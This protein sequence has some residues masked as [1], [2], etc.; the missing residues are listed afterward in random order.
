MRRHFLFS[1]LLVLMM[2]SC[3]S[4]T[5]GLSQ[6]D[7]AAIDEL[8][9]GLINAII[10]ADAT[11]YAEL[12]SED[13][14]L[15]HEGS[16]IITGKSELTAHNIAIFESISVTSLSLTPIK[17]YGTGDLAYEVGTQKLAVEPAS[18]QFEGSR[19]YIHVFRR[20]RDGK[21]RFSA[22]MSSNN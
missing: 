11:A 5:Q 9:N 7:M 12:C 13:V 20:S 4:K 14:H 19:K 22:L 1:L 15:L 21:W 17:I 8:R 2:L 18:P 16:P 10:A 6:R 3:V